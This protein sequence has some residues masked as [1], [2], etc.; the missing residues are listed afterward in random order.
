[1]G[2]IDPNLVYVTKTLRFTPERLVS[3]L[4]TINVRHEMVGTPSDVG[5]VDCNWAYNQRWSDDPNNV[6]AGLDYPYYGDKPE[7][8][9]TFQ[10]QYTEYTDDSGSATTFTDASCDTTDEST[11]VDHIANGNIV[12]GLEVSG[13]GITAGT[14][15]SSISSTTRFLLSADA[16]ADGTDVT[17][18][19][20]GPLT[21]ITQRD[22]TLSIGDFDCYLYYVTACAH[23][24]DGYHPNTG[25]RTTY[26]AAYYYTRPPA[27]KCQSFVKSHLISRINN[28]AETN[29]SGGIGMWKRGALRN[30]W[31]F[32]AA[33]VGGEISTETSTITPYPY[34]Y[35]NGIYDNSNNFGNNL[36]LGE[37][38]NTFFSPVYTIS[39]GATHS[40]A[41]ASLTDI[42][43]NNTDAGSAGNGSTRWYPTAITHDRTY[44]D[45]QVKIGLWSFDESGFSTYFKNRVNVFWQ[46][47]GE[48]TEIELQ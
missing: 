12:E 21:S 25:N 15:I 7:Y 33:D 1:M 42:G 23:L 28:S 30:E 11:Q 27:D 37:G 3:G 2:D 14:T 38:N 26:S 4:M 43:V 34:L 47:F 6:D 8:A 31:G 13:T 5:E 22:R 48:T 9:T 10:R 20:S 41:T 40:G 45:L 18:T 44:W 29:S 24:E 46:P 19:F 36:S 32:P 17:L 16:T 39:I 35:A